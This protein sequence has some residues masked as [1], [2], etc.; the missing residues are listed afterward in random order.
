LYLIT[1]SSI[2]PKFYYSGL[3]VALDCLLDNTCTR[4]IVYVS[5][6]VSSKDSPTCG[7][8]ATPCLTIPYA[9]SQLH[10]V[11][12]K[13]YLLESNVYYQG[14]VR[15]TSGM[16]VSLEGYEITNSTAEDGYP[17]VYPNHQDHTPLYSMAGN[18]TALLSVNRVNFLY[19]NGTSFS[20]SYFSSCYN[21]MVRCV[22]VCICVCVSCFCVFMVLFFFFKPIL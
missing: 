9:F 21:S 16:N 14:A 20:G 6:A 12:G 22:C 3:S 8:G 10:D 17:K 5:S 13:V 7:S 18:G 1:S 4:D 19:R 2:S 11:G 15:L